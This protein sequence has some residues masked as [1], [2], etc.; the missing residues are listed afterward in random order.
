MLGV[1]LSYLGLTLLQGGRTEK[2]RK[3]LILKILMQDIM[4]DIQNRLEFMKYA[5][6]ILF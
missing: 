6:N 2:A 4:N 5:Y 1:L 3:T